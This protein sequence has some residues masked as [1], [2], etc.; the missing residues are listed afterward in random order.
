MAAIGLESHGVVKHRG[1]TPPPSS[2]KGFKMRVAILMGLVF[3]GDNIGKAFGAN[4]EPAATGMI[5]LTLTF[6]LILDVAQFFNERKS[7]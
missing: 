1:P 7:K 6:C 3:I 2:K 4:L 5:I